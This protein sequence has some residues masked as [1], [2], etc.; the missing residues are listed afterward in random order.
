MNEDLIKAWDLA[1]GIHVKKLVAHTA[2]VLLSLHIGQV[3]LIDVGSNVGK[4]PELL[5]AYVPVTDC[6]MIEAIP[7]LAAY[8]AKKFP[9]FQML[10]KVVSNTSG[11]LPMY[12][13][14]TTDNLGMSKV[15]VRNY[16]P[17]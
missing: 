14:D 16:Y 9:N 1:S 11:L 10:N 17:E 5:N 4:F 12:I 15:T 8:T 13:N 3:R 2:N 6:V 7:E